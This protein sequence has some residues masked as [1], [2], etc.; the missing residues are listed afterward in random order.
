MGNHRMLN[1]I[2]S[3]HIIRVATV[4]F[5]NGGHTTH[6]TQN[7]FRSWFYEHACMIYRRPFSHQALRDYRAAE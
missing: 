7:C 1:W 4:G 2:Y 5:V 3:V 6:Q